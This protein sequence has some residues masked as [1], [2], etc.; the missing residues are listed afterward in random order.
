MMAAIPNTYYSY[1]CLPRSSFLPLLALPP[2]LDLSFDNLVVRP[3]AVFFFFFNYILASP[4]RLTTDMSGTLYGYSQS[5][6]SDTVSFVLEDGTLFTVIDTYSKA[7]SKAVIVRGCSF[8]YPHICS[9]PGY[10]RRH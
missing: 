4:R 10:P 2:R 3:G 1:P 6:D 5:N 9:Y 8:P 7:Q